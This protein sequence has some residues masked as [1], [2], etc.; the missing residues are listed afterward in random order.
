MIIYCRSGKTLG[1]ILPA[2][3]HILNQPKLQRGDGPIALVLAPTRELAQQIQKVVFEFGRSSGVRSTCLF[4]GASKFEQISSL[5][6]G[7]EI[8][9]ATPGRLLDL[10]ETSI[11]NLHRCTYLV[12]DEADR[13]LDMGF[14]PQIRK[15][16][17]QIRPDRQTLMWSATWP[18]EVRELAQDYLSQYIHLTVGSLELAANPNITQIVKVCQ[19]ND[20][21]NE[22]REI[23]SGIFDKKDDA[24]GK[25]LIFAQTKRAVDYLARFIDSCGVRCASIHGD[26]SQEQRDNTLNSFRSNRVSILVATDVAARGLD[27]DGIQYVINYDYPN[28]SEDYIHRI[29]RTGRRNNKGTAYTLFT[30]ENGPLA[31]DLIKVLKEAKQEI[32]SELYE[33]SKSYS[34]SKG[35]PSSNRFPYGGG[36]SYGKFFGPRRPQRDQFFDDEEDE[37]ENNYRGNSKR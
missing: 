14:E 4:G 21:Q 11:L 16:L 22:L 18:T 24:P 9:I 32:S 35:R 29:G 23:L 25:V 36:R 13:M 5:R 7:S 27:V 10:L 12:M 20:K 6:R 30:E 31:R 2:L 37:L 33:L 17:S 19:Q 15:I 28:G 3:V 1:F 34:S 26:K 8:V